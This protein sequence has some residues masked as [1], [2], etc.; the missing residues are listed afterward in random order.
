[1]ETIKE[2]AA[3]I[4]RERVL[5]ARE[6]DPTEKFLAG[7]RLFEM[8]CRLT[9]DGIR[10]DFPDADED[11]VREILRQRLEWKERWETTQWQAAQKTAKQSPS[12]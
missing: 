4:F 6:M 7:Q 11:R 5:R 9:M 12:K 8:A 1:M 2:L 3:D 10:D